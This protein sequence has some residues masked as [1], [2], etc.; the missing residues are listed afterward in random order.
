MKKLELLN[1]T[2]VTIEEKLLNPIILK[3]VDSVLKDTK[4]TLL[5]WAPTIFSIGLILLFLLIAIGPERV[6]QGARDN[7][8][9]VIGAMIGIASINGLI[10]AFL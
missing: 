2:V 4:S 6:K 1:Q 7:V 8:F 5:K 3:S 10:S 9:W